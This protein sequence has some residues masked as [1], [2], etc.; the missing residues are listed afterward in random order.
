MEPEN[1]QQRQARLRRQLI[2]EALA[3]KPVASKA[4]PAPAP[5]KRSVVRNRRQHRTVNPVYRETISQQAPTHLPPQVITPFAPLTATF[6]HSGDIGDLLYSLPVVRYLGG[7]TLLL[8]PNGLPSIKIDGSKSGFNPE[9]IKI[10]LP[11]L[12]AQPYISKAGT[13]EDQDVDLDID[14]FRN[15]GVFPANLCEK[16]LTSFGVP[17]SET[18]LSWITCRKNPIAPVVFARSTRYR[19]QHMDYQP[20]YNT[21]SKNAIFVGLPFEHELFQKEVGL[22]PYKPVKNFLE[23]AEIINGSDLFIGNQSSP[24]AL[25]IGLGVPFIQEVFPG[26]PDCIFNNRANARY[27]RGV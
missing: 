13:W 25:A 1:L 12:E 3:K 21:H 9:L 6:K 11:L 10:L 5:Y 27:F 15:I 18:N 20:L 22:I 2:Q 14:R 7:G 19:N 4:P 24:M 8:N 16:I 26:T 17:F 23:L